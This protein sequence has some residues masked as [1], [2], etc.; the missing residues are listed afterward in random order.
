MGIS[1][2]CA[3]ANSLTADNVH[4]RYEYFLLLFQ[5]PVSE[6]ADRVYK[7]YIGDA[8]SPAQIRDGVLDAMGDLYFVISS[9]DVARYH[10]GNS[11]ASENCRILSGRDVDSV[12]HFSLSR[13]LAVFSFSQN[14]F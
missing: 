4:Y 10:R 5:R 12:Q 13:E 6:I 2:R 14:S 9:L 1:Q 11:A 7:M 8:E 3:D